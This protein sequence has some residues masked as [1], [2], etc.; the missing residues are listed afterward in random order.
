MQ[1]K[2]L[3]TFYINDSSKTLDV[4]FRLETDGDEEIRNDSISIDSV[5]NFGYEFLNETVSNNYDDEEDSFDNYYED[6]FN[7]IDEEEVISFLNEYY[8]VNPKKLP[9]SEPF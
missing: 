4:T 3:I 1:V 2:D 9:P 7:P 5:E 8:M 6:D